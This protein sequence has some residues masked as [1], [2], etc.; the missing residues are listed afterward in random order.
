MR[1]G[2][3]QGGWMAFDW[4]RGLETHNTMTESVGHNQSGCSLS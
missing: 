4:T 1:N 2:L 3:I